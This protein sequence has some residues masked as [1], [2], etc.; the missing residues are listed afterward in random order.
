MIP[1]FYF[2]LFSSSFPFRFF[3]DIDAWNNFFLRLL[4]MHMYTNNCAYVSDERP[5]SVA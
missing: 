5:C 4:C 3:F 2:I 1:L